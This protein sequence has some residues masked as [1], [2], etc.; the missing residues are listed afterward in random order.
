MMEEGKKEGWRRLE[1]ILYPQRLVEV[2]CRADHLEPGRERDE[3]TDIAVLRGRSGR[4]ARADWL[5]CF[6]RAWICQPQ[7]LSGERA[8]AGE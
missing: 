8:R 1:G 6:E 5:K 7:A 2:D 3:H 4:S